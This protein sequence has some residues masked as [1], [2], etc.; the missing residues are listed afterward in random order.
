MAKRIRVLIVE[1]HDVVREGLRILIGA[2]SGLEIAG[3]ADNGLAAA[4]LARKLQPDVVVL[5]L[6]M[7]KSNGL[8]ATQEIR[9]LSPHS[10]VLVLSAY[11]DMDTVQRLV[12]AGVAGYLTKHSAA[13]ELLKAI[14]AVSV[15]KSYYSGKIAGQIKARKQSA[16]STGRA[17]GASGRLTPREREVVCLIARGA[18]NKAIALELGLSIKTVEK[19]RQAAM[20][21]LGL[22]DTASLTRYALERG[23][24]APQA[25]APRAAV[26]ASTE[27]KE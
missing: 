20:D 11:Q 22:H 15:G 8:K 3:E 13:D 17:S 23:L 19:H 6:A 4:A 26:L 24:V 5:D 10:R 7:P 14:H 9:R 12:E 16:I 2:D 25:L 18:P 27:S 21:K 1:D